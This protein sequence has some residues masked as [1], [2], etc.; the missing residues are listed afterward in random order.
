MVHYYVS[1]AKGINTAGFSN[2]TGAFSQHKKGG[3]L[4]SPIDQAF[5]AIEAI[6]RKR[7]MYQAVRPTKPNGPRTHLW[8]K[9]VSRNI[10]ETAAVKMLFTIERKP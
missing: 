4:E 8:I 10:T 3:E 7:I 9:K 1:F 6:G 2:I 5:I